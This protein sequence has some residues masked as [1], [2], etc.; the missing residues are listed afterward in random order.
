MIRMFS[1]LVN[2]IVISIIILLYKVRIEKYTN[3][4]F[5]IRH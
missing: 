2:I 4:L 1:P 3:S 5:K